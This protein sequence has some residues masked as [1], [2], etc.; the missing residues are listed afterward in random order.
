MR[1]ALLIIGLVAVVAAVATADFTDVNAPQYEGK[2]KQAKVN[3]AI[4][5][6][7]AKLENGIGGGATAISVTNTEA[8]TVSAGV[9]IVSGIGG[10]NDT[11][12]TITLVAPTVAGQK[13]TLLVATASSNL[14]TIADGTTVAA[15]GAILMDGNDSCVLQ[16]V[17]T[18]TWVLLTE[19]DN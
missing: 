3:E 14:I 4:D 13:V 16:A 18:S 12:N 9:Y 7:F 11:T 15:S 8:V 10:A 17:D 5:A 2:T 19:S 1:R 6:N